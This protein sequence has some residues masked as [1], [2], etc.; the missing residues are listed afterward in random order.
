[1]V[2]LIQA[3]N[4]LAKYVDRELV[5]HL[6]GF[7]RIG[8]ASYVAL[9]TNH[10]GELVT[11]YKDHPAVSVLHII[12]CNTNEID[13]DALHAA[14]YPQFAQR[15]T[16]AIPFIGD[17]TLDQNDIDKIYRYMKGELG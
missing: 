5:P 8:L 1:M 12:D 17:L 4:G 16:I 9:A 14:V 11:K 2:S 10:A 3:Q 6:T 7:K 13:L 15:Q